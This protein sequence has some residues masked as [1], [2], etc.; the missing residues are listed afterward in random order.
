MSGYNAE[1][2]VLTP[3]G[4]VPFKDLPAEAVV[5]NM[6][7]PQKAWVAFID[8]QYH[9]TVDTEIEENRHFVVHNDRAA[10]AQ[11]KQASKTA[12]AEASTYGGRASTE[13]AVETGY[14]LQQ[15]THPTGFGQQ[16][17]AEMLTTALAGAG[18]ATSGIKGLVLQNEAQRGGTGASTTLDE[19]TRQK[20]QSEAKAS[21]AIAAS[22]VQAKLQQQQEAAADLG[23]KYGVDVSAQL[24]QGSLQDKLINTQIEAGKSGWFQNLMQGI[25]TVTGA[26]KNVASAMYGGGSGF[27]NS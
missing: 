24:G 13:G 3:Q 6:A 10:Q 27:A 22:D 4:Y 18:G 1:T 11:A 2:R 5:L 25:S 8:G 15:L 19:L 17:T 20:M 9:L 14:D 23:R 26:A 12:A 7:G 21:E 16:G